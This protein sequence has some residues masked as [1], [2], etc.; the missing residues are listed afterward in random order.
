VN[1]KLSVPNGKI[2]LASKEG[3]L[4]KRTILCREGIWDGMFGTVHVTR[5]M[6]EM[7][8]DRYNKQR[9]KPLNENDYA[10]ILKNHDRDV[11]G[12]LGRLVPPLAVEDF[13]DPETGIVGAALMGDVRIDDPQ[14]Q[15]KVDAGKYAQGS[16]NFDDQGQTEI[17][18]W[19]FVAVEAARR[20]QV[21]EQGDKTMSVELQ[22]QLEAANAK[23]QA[24]AAKMAQHKLTRKEALLAMSSNLA[25]SQ[26]ALS[27]FEGIVSQVALQFRQVALTSQLRG[28]MREGKLSKAEFDKIDLKKLAAMDIEASKMVLGSYET[29]KP[30]TDIV[31]HGQEGAQPVQLSGLPPSEVRA[32]MEAQKLGK[33]YVPTQGGGQALADGGKTDPAGGGGADD[34]KTGDKGAEEMKL[35]DVEETL[36]KLNECIPGVSKLREHMKSMDEAIGKMRGADEED[37]A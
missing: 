34:K 25:L 36:K 7:L 4:Y 30:S 10:P 16:L 2:N 29:R 8:A 11:D 19:S 31:Q 33:P 13:A 28:F 12:I 17:F 24:L 23:N 22:K 1:Y 35:S 21:L 14:A 5:Q 26:T 32:M 3:S 6:L 18:E 37:A 15:V 20:S 9:A 27:S